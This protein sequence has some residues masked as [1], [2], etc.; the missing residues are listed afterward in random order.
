MLLGFYNVQNTATIPP[1]GS[2]DHFFDVFMHGFSGSFFHLFGN[3][4]IHIER[5]SNR[6]MS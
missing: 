3:V 2:T 1:Q 6:C 4:T 5:K